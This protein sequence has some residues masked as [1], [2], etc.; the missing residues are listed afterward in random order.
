MEVYISAKVGTILLYQSCKS[1]AKKNWRLIWILVA[2]KYKNWFSLAPKQGIYITSR[3]SK[4]SN[5][6]AEPLGEVDI[7]RF[8]KSRRDIYS[9][10][11]SQRKS[12]FIFHIH[13]DSLQNLLAMDFQLWYNKIVPTFTEIYTSTL[14]EN[15]IW[16]LSLK[17][18]NKK[19]RNCKNFKRIANHPKAPIN[20]NTAAES[21]TAITKGEQVAHL[22]QTVWDD[23]QKTG[24]RHNNWTSKWAFRLYI[25]PTMSW[26]L[27]L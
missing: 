11:L 13:K 17:K 15:A 16:L 12:V 18:S 25:G 3:L 8:R 22:S 20:P 2:M 14:K 21:D 23:R 4:S 24:S 7:W 27:W 19:R 6:S 5:I 26:H 1:N 10:F 9:L